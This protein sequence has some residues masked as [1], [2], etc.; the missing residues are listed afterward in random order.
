MTPLS[1]IE[2]LLKDL[3][4]ALTATRTSDEHR[5]NCRIGNLCK[6]CARLQDRVVELRFDLLSVRELELDTLLASLREA[7]AEPQEA[8]GGRRTFKQFNGYM[9]FIASVQRGE[10]AVV[11]GPNYVVL[12]RNKYDELFGEATGDPAPLVEKE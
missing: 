4:E 6:E 5:W 11:F 2:A 12:S 10:H 7:G 3:R 9:Q 8:F 1:Q